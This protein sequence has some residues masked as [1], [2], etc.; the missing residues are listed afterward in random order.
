MDVIIVMLA[1]GVG[2]LIGAGMHHRTKM[3]SEHPRHP[4]M[5]QTCD[6]GDDIVRLGKKV[7]I[8]LKLK[9]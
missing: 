5:D 8:N 2:V 7:G 9:E 3:D 4:S 1:L 6:L